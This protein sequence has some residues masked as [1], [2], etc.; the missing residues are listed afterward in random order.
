MRDYYEVLGVNKKATPEEIKQSYRKLALKYHPDKNKG[1]PASE[2]KFKEITEAY[3]VLKDSN[4]RSAYDYGGHSAV[5][6]GGMGGGGGGFSSG[7]FSDIFSDLFG[8]FMGGGQSSTTKNTRGSDLRYNLKIT[9]EEAFKGKE[10]IIKFVSAVKCTECKGSGSKSASSS[11]CSTCNGMGKTLLRQGFFTIE[12]TCSSCN[13]SGEVI[14]D[15]CKSCNGN[16]RKSSERT[17]SIDIPKG[18]EDGMRIRLAGEGE[19]GLRGASSGD[20]FV[21]ISIESHPFF[22][23]DKNNIHCDVPIKMTVAALGGEIEVP[24]IDGIAAKIFIPAGTQYDDK[25]RLRNKGMSI[26]RSSSRG[27]MYIHM[28]VETP[29]KL[30]KKQKTLLTEFEDLNNSD[31]NPKYE[32]FIKKVKRFWKEIKE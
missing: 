5:N 28:R 22:V 24:A 16:G 7:D 29:T 23:R 4:K 20:L 13:G 27:D 25:L 19:V 6:N 15:P 14:K 8:D 18:V 9:L 31:N 26:L 3:E 10:E 32:N 2:E 1:D 21:F 12:K 11:K 30:S 17:I